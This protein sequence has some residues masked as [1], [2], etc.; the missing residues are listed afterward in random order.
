MNFMCAQSGVNV[1]HYK[2]G[3]SDYFELFADL[4]I[5]FNRLV[6]SGGGI[7]FYGCKQE[8]N[9]G[10]PIAL[11]LSYYN[12]CSLSTPQNGQDKLVT[13]V[14]IN[15]HIVTA[16]GYKTVN[17]YKIQSGVETLFRTDNYLFVETGWEL[18]YWMYLGYNMTVDDAYGI[19]VY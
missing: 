13:Q 6:L 12:V 1:A 7:H 3:L 16:S 4:I 15:N 9:A 17:Y 5:Y 18:S 8:I 19:G 14:Y 2:E 11:F 10:R